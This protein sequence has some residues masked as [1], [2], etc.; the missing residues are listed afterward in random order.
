MPHRTKMRRIPTSGRWCAREAPRH[1]K[2]SCDGISRWFCAVAYSACGEL[3]Q[4]E[5]VAQET[6]WAAWRGRESLDQPDRLSSW[7]CGIARNLGKT[8]GAGHL[9]RSNRPPA[10]TT[11]PTDRPM[12]R[13]PPSKHFPEKRNRSSGIRSNRFPTRFE[14]R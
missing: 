9:D 3:S 6:F 10:W 14:S 7:L 5:D 1:L 12:C 13:D 8:P 11:S 2:C 4:S